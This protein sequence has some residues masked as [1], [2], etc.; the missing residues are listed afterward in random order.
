LSGTLSKAWWLLVLCG[1]LDAMHASINLLM[2]SHPLTYQ[3]FGSSVTAGWDM[4]LLALA[5]GVCVIG[6]GLWCGGKDRSWLLSLHGLAMGAFGAVV[7]SPL[8]KGPLSFR[9]ISVLFTLM[10]ASLGAFALGT[11]KTQRRS[12]KGRWLLFAAGAAFIGFAVSFIVIGGFRIRLEPPQTFFIWM[13]SFL[14]L[15]TMF[16]VWLAFRVHSGGVRQSVQAEPFSPAPSP[17]H[18]H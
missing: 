6:A 18:T 2:I 7:L 10:A 4:G 9:P 5:A 8:V 12:S 1:I 14:S 13:S 16:M 15:C 3:I 17:I 11:A